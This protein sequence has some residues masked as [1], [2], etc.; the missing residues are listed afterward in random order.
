MPPT[1]REVKMMLT[2]AER[3]LL[4]SASRT[5]IIRVLPTN[6][7]TAGPTFAIEGDPSVAVDYVKVLES[8]VRLGLAKRFA[9]GY[10]PL[11]PRGLREA[12]KLPGE[13]CQEVRRRFTGRIEFR[14]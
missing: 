4:A 13:I 10:Y 11:T 14:F 1:L 5:G 8:L 3:E 7:V 2:A 12:G 9:E 6:V